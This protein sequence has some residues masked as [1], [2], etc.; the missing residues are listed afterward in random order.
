MH[1]NEQLVLV[2]RKQSH[3]LEKYF[4]TNKSYL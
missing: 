3:N 2:D 1:K 4:E